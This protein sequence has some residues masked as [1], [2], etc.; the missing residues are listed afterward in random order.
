[1]GKEIN[2]V[3]EHWPQFLRCMDMQG[4]R[5]SQQAE[6]GDHA[7][8]SEAMVTMQMGDEDMAQFGETNPTA[9]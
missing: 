1:M 8:Q 6:G 3:L 9:T 2:L 5:P 4:S 7:N